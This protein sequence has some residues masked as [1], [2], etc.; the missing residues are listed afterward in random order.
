MDARDLTPVLPIWLWPESG[1]LRLWTPDATYWYPEVSAISTAETWRRLTRDGQS[2][3]R[4]EA[5]LQPVVFARQL[6]ELL[7]ATGVR[8]VLFLADRRPADGEPKAIQ[9]WPFQALPLEWLWLDG[10][11]LSDLTVARH[12]PLAENPAAP[13]APGPILIADLWP[14]TAG[15][16]RPLAGLLGDQPELAEI[17]NIRLG[18]DASRAAILHTHPDNYAALVIFCHGSEDSDGQTPL[19]DPQRQPWELPTA[20]GLPPLVILLAC[21][22]D[23]GNLVRYGRDL[24]AQ[25]ARAVL[26]PFG[27]LDAP[28]ARR[29]LDSF[30]PRW[31]AG[32]RI[33]LAL[34][35]AQRDDTS[36]WGA[37]RL[38]IVGDPGLRRSAERQLAE[39]TDEELAALCQAYPE[40]T[41]VALA[42]LANRLTLWCF[43]QGLKLDRP[44][45]R[46]RELFGIGHADAAGERWLFER[47]DVVF[48]TAHLGRL[49]QLWLAPW[50]AQLAERHDHTRLSFY[51][52]Q[53]RI[54]LPVAD[55]APAIVYHDWNRVAYRRGCYA[56]A[57]EDVLCGLRALPPAQL[58]PDGVPLVRSLANLLI[59]FDLPVAA[60]TVARHL[61]AR[62]GGLPS[63]EAL[64]TERHYL[65]DTHARACLRGG[66]W[67]AALGLFRRKREE[68]RRRC[69]EQASDHSRDTPADD[70]RR[71]LAWLLYAAS[72]G[73]P[74]SAE[75]AGFA[76]EVRTLLHDS[77][78]FKNVLA[79]EQGNSDHLYLLRAFAAWVWRSGIDTDVELL[80]SYRDVME[81][82]LYIRQDPGPLGFMVGYLNLSAQVPGSRLTDPPCWD[83]AREILRG[84]RYFLEA[85][86]FDAL[87]GHSGE[88]AVSLKLFQS[89]CA[90][91]SRILA[92]LAQEGV[93]LAALG[94]ATDML[95]EWATEARQ[96]QALE[97]AWFSTEA[98]PNPEDLLAQ[99]LLP[100]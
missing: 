74:R 93:D 51:E 70:G 29:F 21:G 87:L 39:R 32:E 91:F 42:L 86:G 37:R 16:P 67:R 36:D 69:A 34:Q 5:V 94:I 40:Q 60:R 53:R 22:S 73:D 35:E 25:G 26:A 71:E 97:C 83:A 2:Q 7:R 90:D 88:A 13:V 54:L 6:A 62:L 14:R 58:W 98:A 75:T 68:A 38:A 8:P 65:K 33:D 23:C 3:T 18:P 96:R 89:Q 56:Q 49:T 1:G 82:D 99:G 63:N 80:L 85:A 100:L 64:E 24:L 30:L 41:T 55:L 57:L 27:Q 77:V 61:D 10:A 19:T 31:L 12:V 28:H 66:D 52:A 20:N 15:T 79:A 95:L 84:D 50:L 92:Q 44:R 59:E 11:S 17:V 48:K 46:L 47:L 76:A 4:L 43:Q 45:E 9:E 72:W 81:S 78:S